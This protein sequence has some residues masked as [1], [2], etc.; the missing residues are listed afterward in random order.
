MNEKK[1]TQKIASCLFAF[2]IIVS[3]SFCGCTMET[4]NGTPSQKYCTVVLLDNTFCADLGTPQKV[5]RGEDAVFQFT[6]KK[7][8]TFESV[9]YRDYEVNV[10]DPTPNGERAVALTLH[11]VKYTE[12]LEVKVKVAE[13]TYFSTIFYHANGGERLDG[14]KDQAIEV[15]YNLQRHYRPNAERGTY[16]FK[17][18]NHVQIG[19]N[20]EADGS[21]THVGLGSKAPVYDG[22]RL[23]LYAEWARYTNPNFFEY[24]LIDN[25]CLSEYYNGY[26]KLEEIPIS[27]DGEDCSAVITKYTGNDESKLVIPEFIDNYEVVAIAPGAVQSKENITTVVLPKSIRIVEDLAFDNCINFEK[28]YLSD[29]LARLRNNAFGDPFTVK[30]LH[31]NAVQTPVFGRMEASQVANKIEML[32]NHDGIRPKLVIFGSCTT[33]YGVSAAKIQQAFPQ[34]DVFN[35]GVIG[36]ICA[37]YQMDLIKQ[38][39]KEGDVFLQ[40]AELGSKYQLYAAVDFAPNLFA[41]LENNYDYLAELNL[42][43]YSNVIPSLDAHFLNRKTMASISGSYSDYL[44]TMSEQGDLLKDRTGGFENKGIPYEPLSAETIAEGNS[45]TEMKKLFGEISQKGVK[46]YFA[47]G[48]MNEEGLDQAEVG[49]IEALFHAQFAAKAIPTA[50]INEASD[51]IMSKQYFSDTNY[52]LT[53]EGADIYTDTLIDGLKSHLLS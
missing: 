18:S 14:V 28:L 48:P 45:F 24:F 20:T 29:N 49:E 11:S 40:I 32:R 4:G 9:N 6:I 36:G 51:G 23:N 53:M 35:M 27:Q 21:G 12:A 50:I 13:K 46:T 16:L 37:M 39:L 2:I 25:E 8:Y 43:N 44:D 34:Y 1:I 3:L 52:H 10:S 47:F 5:L 22:G 41:T 7:G 26:K 38:S 42:Q 17:R 33:F 31:I 15:N 30:T 19:W